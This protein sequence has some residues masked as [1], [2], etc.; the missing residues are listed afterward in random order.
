MFNGI[1]FNTGIIKVIKKT[2]QSILIGIKSNF[3]IARTAVLNDWRAYE[4]ISEKLQLNPDIVAAA[5]PELKYHWIN[6]VKIDPYPYLLST[7]IFAPSLSIIFLTY[8][9]PNPKPF[10]LCMLP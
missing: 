2:E 9:K 4:Y 8:D 6:K 10:T 5:M 3:K 1:I 7:N